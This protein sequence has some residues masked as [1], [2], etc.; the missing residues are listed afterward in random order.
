TAR[1]DRPSPATTAAHILVADENA[2]ERADLARLL[3]NRWNVTAVADGAAALQA[4]R[5]APVDLILSTV[6][7]PVMDGISLL[8]AVRADD[9]LA[10]IPEIMLSTRAGD[11]SGDD[12]LQAKT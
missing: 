3:H 2:D 8:H 4:I 5:R 6:M 11:D 1:L 9:A 12:E 10:T 7:M